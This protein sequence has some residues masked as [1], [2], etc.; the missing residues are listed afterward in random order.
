MKAGFHGRVAVVDVEATCLRGPHCRV[1]ALALIPLE[2]GG[3]SLQS[4]V[5]AVEPPG[6]AVGDT[7]LIHGVTSGDAPGAE[8]NM[9]LEE[10]VG[11]AL[12]YELLVVYGSHD[13]DLL[14][15]EASR[16]GL[17]V[18]RICYVDLLSHL[19]SN[20][21]RRQKALERGGYPLE[22][23]VRDVL[24]LEVENNHFHDPVRDALY[25]GLLYQALLQRGERLRG[26]CREPRSGRGLL[27][28]LLRLAPWRGR[29]RI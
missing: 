4:L 26:T 19:L 27:G 9:G 8:P 28:R 11:L 2:R 15:S 12:S 17:R 25:T 16:R 6:E 29:A 7:A 18:G 13:V 22:E 10:A 23:A 24:G 3:L 21:L 14:L 20:P 5:Y 1:V